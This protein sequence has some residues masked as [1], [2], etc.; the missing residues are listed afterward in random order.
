[1][2]I[3]DLFANWQAAVQR[4][5]AAQL[6][7]ENSRQDDL[8]K[9]AGL[10]VHTGIQAGDTAYTIPYPTIPYPPNDKYFTNQRGYLC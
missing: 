1:M 3:H 7:G 4:A 5:L 2:T 9:A 6:S 8:L 10:D